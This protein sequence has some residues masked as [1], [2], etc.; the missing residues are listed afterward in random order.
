MGAAGVV[1]T[2]TAGAAGSGGGVSAVWVT[3]DTLAVLADL[4]AFL[5]IWAEAVSEAKVSRPMQVKA[6]AIFI[7]NNCVSTRKTVN[8]YNSRAL[9]DMLGN[10]HPIIKCPQGVQW[11][12]ATALVA[13]SILPTAIAQG[14][15]TSVVANSALA[16]II[17]EKDAHIESITYDPATK[18]FYLGSI[19]KRK[20]IQRTPDNQ[21]RDFVP[22]GQDSLYAVLGV[23]VDANRRVLWA[24]TTA[25]PQMQDYTTVDNNKVA[26]F[27]YDL[28]TKRLLKK[29]TLPPTG[30]LHVLGEPVVAANGDVYISDS[31][32]PAIYRIKQGSDHLEL[33]LSTN[34]RSLQGIAFSANEQFMF[35][36]DYATGIYRYNMATRQLTQLQKEANINDRGTDGL[37]VYKDQLV[38]IQNGVSPSRVVRFRLDKTQSRIQA[39]DVLEMRNPNFNEPTLGVVV[40]HQL[41]YVA[42]SQWDNYTKEGLIFPLE[43]LAPILILVLS[44]D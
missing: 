12:L 37:Y 34:L 26:V 25:L 30:Q 29:Y 18:T 41:Y 2:A 20:I 28:S 33:F 1:G 36:A 7:E 10:N 31:G 16:F 14:V 44:L 35:I 9:T 22:T 32:Y 6:D 43:K 4:V 23:R 42:N 27:A 38:A 15:A 24:C 8:C 3:V 11:L 5:T 13:L 39:M 17:Q 21:F 19:H 40:G